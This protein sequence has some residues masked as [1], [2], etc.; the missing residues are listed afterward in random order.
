MYCKDARDLLNYFCNK[1]NGNQDRFNLFEK[2]F[3]L[4]HS[5]LFSYSSCFIFKFKIKQF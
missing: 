1:V 3:E 5:E 2:H 4:V